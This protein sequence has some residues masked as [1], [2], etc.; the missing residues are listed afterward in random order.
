MRSVGSVPHFEVMVG[1]LDSS[2]P[3]KLTREEGIVCGLTGLLHRFLL[4]QK[5][6]H[7]S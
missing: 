1:V 6:T 3:L 4:H 7:P 5:G 2:V